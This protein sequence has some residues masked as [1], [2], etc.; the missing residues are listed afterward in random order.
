[1]IGRLGRRGAMTSG[2]GKKPLRYL[3]FSKQFPCHSR[4]DY[5]DW[6]IYWFLLRESGQ[7][8][9]PAYAK[10]ENN[11]QHWNERGC[12]CFQFFPLYFLITRLD[13]I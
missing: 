6:L 8:S 5:G 11:D 12:D 4:S 9:Q 1:M 10:E 3:I 7:G 13:S 2:Q